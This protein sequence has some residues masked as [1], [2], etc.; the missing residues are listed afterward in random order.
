MVAKKK[1]KKQQRSK[2]FRRKSLAAKRGWQTRQKKIKAKSLAA[3]RGWQTRQK[4]IKAFRDFEKVKTKEKKLPEIKSRKKSK[5][6]LSKEKKRIKELEKKI[7]KLQ[8]LE[9]KRKTR[10]KELLEQQTAKQKEK[11]PKEDPWEKAERLVDAA[12][13]AGVFYNT[14]LLIAKATGLTPREIYTL[15][16]SPKSFGRA[17]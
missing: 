2:E 14:Y 15:G 17:A 5:K 11:R 12:L 8:E 9:K 7:S 16:V 3:K 6:T 4:K 1:K 10:I 13:K